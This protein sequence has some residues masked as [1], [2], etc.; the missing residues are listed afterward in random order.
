MEFK[1]KQSIYI[2]ITNYV[3]EQILLEQWP[4]GERIPSVRDSAAT[5]EVD[6]NTV[7]RAY[8]F[9][10]S[11]EIIFNKRGIGYSAAE[12]AKKLILAYRRERFLESELPGFFKILYLLN[13]PVEELQT[14]YDKFVAAEY[15]TTP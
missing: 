8:D 1:G 2:Q 12:D 6:P 14:R 7:M 10:Q 11:Q 15:P 4:P 9:M 5:L 13:I 3:C